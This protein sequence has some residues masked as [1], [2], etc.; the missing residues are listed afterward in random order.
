MNS[1]YGTNKN[2]P[3]N[4]F[5]P[6]IK[7]MTKKQIQQILEKII[8][9]LESDPFKE[10]KI[11]YIQ[12]KF[13]LHYQHQIFKKNKAKN[14]PDSITFTLN[15][16]ITKYKSK[17]QKTTL[18]KKDKEYLSS[19]IILNLPPS[20]SD[21][22]HPTDP[23]TL[24]WSQLMFELDEKIHLN[25][26]ITKKFLEKIKN[27]RIYTTR[28]KTQKI[29]IDQELIY[30]KAKYNAI[31]PTFLKIKKEIE[32]HGLTFNPNTQIT[33]NCTWIAGDGDGNESADA[34]ALNYNFNI[35][36]KT[37]KNL[38]K[39]DLKKL[40]LK[41]T[42]KNF[43]KYQTPDQLLQAINNEKTSPAKK[44]ELQTKI[45][46]FGFHLAKTDIRHEASELRNLP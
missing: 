34:K 7:L 43:K 23:T 26:S 44:L 45:N 25:Q 19:L 41:N 6:K 28:K 21:T 4:Q 32:K 10:A 31:H 33:K 27:T 15:K 12:R 36:Q 30:Q 24:K 29:E 39:E 11:I 42:L 38:Y 1:S 5:C 22:A 37:I 8:Q 18:N 14:Y 3:Q 16:I 20:T 13:S 46:H 35:F 17:Y 2:L 40:K 9:T